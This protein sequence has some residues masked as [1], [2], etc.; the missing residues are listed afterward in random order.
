MSR[1]QGQ[2]GTPTANDI[3]SPILDQKCFDQDGEGFQII[4]Q[5][6]MARSMRKYGHKVGEKDY[7]PP[8]LFFT[9]AVEIFSPSLFSRWWGK[10]FPHFFGDGEWE[11][12]GKKFPP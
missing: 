2:G 10:I 8:A 5:L 1:W 12:G 4:S 3:L 6:L 11:G 9:M 7:L